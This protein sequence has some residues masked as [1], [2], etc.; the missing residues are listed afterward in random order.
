MMKKNE[1]WI[2]ESCEKKIELPGLG[3][4]F[5]GN[6]YVANGK[7]GLIGDNFPKEQMSFCRDEVR[8]TTLCV[9]CTLKMLMLD[10]VCTYDEDKHLQ[11]LI[12]ER[13]SNETKI[14]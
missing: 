9:Y 14:E 11:C 6:V 10:S 5:E 13:K 3:F 12:N 1:Q 7:G 8:R 4:V 2:C